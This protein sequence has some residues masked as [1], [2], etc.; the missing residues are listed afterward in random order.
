M[1]DHL[2]L[3]GS[4][5]I[6][7]PSKSDL[8]FRNW[9]QARPGDIAFADWNGVDFHKLDHSGVITGVVNGIPQ[10]AQHTENTT[11]SLAVWLTANRD[12]EPWKNN[13]NTVAIWIVRP[14]A[15]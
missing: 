8:G 9:N 6:V 13:G 5:W 2:K 15:G 10:V 12:G 3:I 4:R 7:S 14:N 1:A 11:E